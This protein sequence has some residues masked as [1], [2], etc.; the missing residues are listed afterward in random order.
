MDGVEEVGG[1]DEEGAV[2]LSVNGGYDEG[3]AVELELELLH[4]PSHKLQVLHLADSPPNSWRRRRRARTVK[5][6]GLPVTA[7][8]VGK[9]RPRS[10]GIWWGAST[11]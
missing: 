1:G 10:E 2:A 5:W 8:G 11:R 4:D 3:L 9:L 6:R 7:T